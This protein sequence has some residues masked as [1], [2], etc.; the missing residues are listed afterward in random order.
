MISQVDE[1]KSKLDITDV[2]QEYFP[3]KQAGANMKAVCPFHDEKTPSF[4][5]SRERQMWHCFGACNEGG[6][7]FTFI[8]KME[9]IEFPEALKILARKAGVELK[10]QDPKVTNL[11]TRLISMQ[12]VAQ[13]FFTSQLFNSQ[14]GKGALEYLRGKRKLSDE[15]I[16]EWQLGHALDSWDALS[17]HFFLLILIYLELNQKIHNIL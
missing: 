4:M 1:I 9:S 3:L 15:T 6:D 10:Y 2:I 5:V 17:K 7:M 12:E 11:K 14:A 16:K 13:D 8:Q